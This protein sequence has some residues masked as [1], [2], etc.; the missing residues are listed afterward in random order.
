[1]QDIPLIV[2]TSTIRND[3]RKAHRVLWQEGFKPGGWLPR[4]LWKKWPCFV[5]YVVMIAGFYQTTNR[6]KPS[7]G[8]PVE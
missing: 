2:N 6:P 5:E 1:M 4:G 8:G 7:L 3:S